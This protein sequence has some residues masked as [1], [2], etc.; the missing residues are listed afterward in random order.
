MLEMDTVDVSE[1]FMNSL[2]H[3][4]FSVES[5]GIWFYIFAGWLHPRAEFKACHSCENRHMIWEIASTFQKQH[6]APAEF[7]CSIPQAQIAKLEE[8]LSRALINALWSFLLWVLSRNPYLTVR[9]LFFQVLSWNP[10]RETLSASSVRAT[11]A[12]QELSWGE[13]KI[14]QV[15]YLRNPPGL[16]DCAFCAI[17]IYVYI[18]YILYIYIHVY[19]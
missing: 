10:Q 2:G 8:G 18:N 13:E 6:F 11:T 9:T 4:D 5:L 17:Y 16:L 15:I 1:S 19:Y 12:W 3:A 7:G 14:R